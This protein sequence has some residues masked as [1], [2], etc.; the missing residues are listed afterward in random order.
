MSRIELS[1]SK[2]VKMLSL[3]SQKAAEVVLEPVSDALSCMARC[4]HGMAQQRFGVGDSRTTLLAH[5][6]AA[7]KF[8]TFCLGHSQCSA[9]GGIL[10]S[11]DWLLASAVCG[12]ECWLRRAV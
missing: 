2:A 7:V 5:F 11:Q 8:Q 4:S 3:G 9:S 12:A 6:L 1:F 10:G